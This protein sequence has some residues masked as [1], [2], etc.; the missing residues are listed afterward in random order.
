MNA[1]QK[2]IS[3]LINDAKSIRS[4]EEL[5]RYNTDGKAEAPTKEAFWMRLVLSL[6]SSQQRSTSSSLLDSFE[7]TPPFPLTLQTYETMSDEQVREVLKNFRFGKPVADYLRINYGRL[8]GNS[9]LWSIVEPE[10]NR[11]LEQRNNP[12]SP[13]ICHK[14]LERK[15]S[16]L[17]AEHLKGIGPK[18]SRNLLQWL[19]LTRYEIPL[20]SR[21]TGWLQE[22][23]GWYISR[24][25][26]GDPVSY[27]FWLD[28]VQ[29]VCEGAGVLPT[30]F[31]AAAFERGKA[32]ST[33]KSLTTC[34]GYTNRNG[35]V[36]IRYTALPGTDHGQTVYQLG[37]SLC[38]HVYGANGSDIFERKCPNCQGGAAGLPLKLAI[39]DP[40]DRSL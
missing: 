19:G 33:G 32:M 24:D 6:L 23:L 22:N 18:Q 28:R 13:D 3:N 34:I 17:L 29:S 27:E 7:K 35:Q 1:E 25:S 4:V 15:V 26:L 11:L 39:P 10:L 38:G 36:V 5:I 21:V 20:D 14:N 30:V 40:M 2:V 12:N 31:D 8:F 37:C 16:H 9:N